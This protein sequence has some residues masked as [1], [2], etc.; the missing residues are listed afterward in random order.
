MASIERTAYPHFRL[1]PTA[2]QLQAHYTPVAEEIA[3]AARVTRRPAHL[4]GLV[5]LLRCF[6]RLGYFPRLEIIPPVVVDHIRGVLGLPAATPLAYDS[7]R[8]L[9]RHHQLIRTYLQITPYGVTARHLATRAVARAAEVLEQPVDLINTAIEELVTQRYELP[10]FSRLDRLV[11]AV[12]TVVNRR[13]F[14]LV[15]VRLTP[16]LADHL[17]RLLEVE[18]GQRQSPFAR[19]KEVAGS[20]TLSHLDEQVRHLAWLGALPDPTP[21]L[22]GLPQAKR[23]SFAAEGAGARRRRTQ[24]GDG[25][26]APRPAALPAA[27]CPRPGARRAG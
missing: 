1:I 26:Q 3:W 22:T 21:L 10:G 17:D 27:S 18:P 24:A 16:A 2:Q 25:P 5:V 23:R 15:Q 8:T 12:R 6:E 11:R 4:L 7:P 13:L 9:Y 19:L 14:R 20:P